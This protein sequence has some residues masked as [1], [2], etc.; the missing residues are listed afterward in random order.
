MRS[1]DSVV[2]PFA[3][4]S[5]AIIRSHVNSNRQKLSPALSFKVK[6]FRA[7]EAILGFHW[8]VMFQVGL[9]V[10]TSAFLGP[11]QEDEGS[12]SA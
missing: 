12:N 10:H 2:S 8:R 5:L 4:I 9:A 6:V 7:K 3:C 1:P 11:R